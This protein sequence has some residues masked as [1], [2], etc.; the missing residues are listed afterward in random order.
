MATPKWSDRAVAGSMAGRRARAARGRAEATSSRAGRAR[1]SRGC[2]TSCATRVLPH[3]RGDHEGLVGLPDGDA[4]Y[5][6]TI[7]NHVGLPK[8]PAELHALG[9]AEI[10]RTDARARRARRARSSARP[11]SPRRSRGCATTSRSTSRLARG[12]PRRRAAG[13]RPREGRDPALLRVLPKTDCVMR[14]IP[15]YEAPYSTIAYYR[16]PHYD[17]TQARRVLRQHVQARDAAA[18]RARGADLARVD[19]RP[20]P[21]DRA[22]AGARRAAGVPQAR[23]LDRVRRG[24]GAVHRAAR[25]RDGPVLERP[26]PARPAS[27]TTRGARRGSSSTPASTRSAGRARRRRRS[28]ARTPR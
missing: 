17:G 20:S 13:A 11:I 21:A 15:D 1:R 10:A 18:L 8:T 5:R 27:A 28:C 9:L 22:R 14:E 7:L 19:P 25:R 2:A 26:R 3:A 23:R 12:D 24:L 4:C 6:A 16:Q